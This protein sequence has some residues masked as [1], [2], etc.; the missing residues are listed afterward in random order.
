MLNL[1]PTES[2]RLTIFMA[3]EFARRNLREGIRISHP[4]AVALITDEV[5]LLARSGVDYDSI[6]QR[7]GSIL[8]PDQVEPGVA[9]MARLIVVELPLE[10]GTKLLALQDPIEHGTDDPVPGEIIPHQAEVHLEALQGAATDRAIEVINEG[11]RDIQ[12]R[13]MTHFFEV[14]RALRFDRRAAYG[15][16]LGIPAGAGVRF[17]PGV[18]KQVTLIPIAGDRV[19]RGQAGLVNGALDD[20]DVRERAFRLARD[21]G[22]LNESD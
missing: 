2:G 22:Y 8:S 11:D 3:A 16:R 1:S 15:M 21:R 18:L 6:R 4:E 7:A 17:E 14:N 5:M 9:A 12:V 19:V 20:P 10:E 13:S